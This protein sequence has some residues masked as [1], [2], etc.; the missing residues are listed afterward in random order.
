LKIDRQIGREGKSS[1][2]RIPEIDMVLPAEAV[3]T[4]FETEEI[5]KETCPLG[6]AVGRI[7]GEFIHLYPPGIPILAPG[8]RIYPVI[9][10]RIR[11]YLK[12][13]F[14]IYGMEDG[15]LPVLK[16]E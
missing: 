7:S 8:E 5:P 9:A 2:K 16:R 14:E 12:D 15:K 1:R 13:G 4:I 3:C 11:Q 10:E 6:Q